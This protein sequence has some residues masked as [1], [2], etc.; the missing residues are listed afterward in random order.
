[1][2]DL[3]TKFGTLRD[4]PCQHCVHCIAAREFIAYTRCDYIE[5]M[6]RDARKALEGEE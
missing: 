1:M 3:K 5:Q 6:A 2:I 4:L